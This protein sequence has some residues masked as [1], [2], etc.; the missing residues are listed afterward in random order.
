MR[1]LTLHE[2]Q[3]HSTELEEYI[4]HLANTVPVFQEGKVEIRHACYIIPGDTGYIYYDYPYKPVADVFNRDLNNNKLPLH[5]VS[6]ETLR[7]FKAFIAK[8][9]EDYPFIYYKYDYRQADSMYALVDMQTNLSF[10]NDSRKHICDYLAVVHQACHLDSPESHLAVVMEEKE[11]SNN[12]YY[13]IQTTYMPLH[14]A[15]SND[16]SLAC[17][18][19]I[20]EGKSLLT[21]AELKQI[22]Y[23]IG[24]YFTSPVLT[25]LYDERRTSEMLVYQHNLKNLHLV[26]S[27]AAFQLL[28]DKVENPQDREIYKM[29]KNKLNAFRIFSDVLLKIEHLKA[30]HSDDSISPFLSRGLVATLHFFNEEMNYF[31]VKPVVAVSKD[32]SRLDRIKLGLALYDRA[33]ILWNLYK[34]SC[35]AASKEVDS[36]VTIEV[37][38]SDQRVGVVFTNRGLMREDFIAFCRKEASYPKKPN[39]NDIYRYGGLQ[40]VRDKCDDHHWDL[41]VDCIAGDDGFK[42][43]I[44]I[45]F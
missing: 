7:S 11:K 19:L 24:C 8:N 29:E 41:L 21:R 25:K 37:I 17:T 26:E 14:I 45:I 13:R 35:Q 22:L 43:K 1:Q 27:L 15:G 30:G 33:S 16:T 38:E 34:N 20:P 23:L 3:T 44:T 32:I 36:T 10:D 9:Q 42:T 6:E 2:K 39:M 28:I 5:H 31:K 18:F 4:S 40:I 12:S